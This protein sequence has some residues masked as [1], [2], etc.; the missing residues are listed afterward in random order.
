M[1]CS[2]S[3]EESNQSLTIMDNVSFDIFV[4]AL[5]ETEKFLSIPIA[6]SIFIIMGCWIVS[7]VFLFQLRWSCGFGHLTNTVHYSDWFGDITSGHDPRHGILLFFRI[8]PTSSWYLILF[9]YCWI[10]F[11]SILKTFI[12]VFVRNTDL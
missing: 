11:A 3:L 6:L 12:P 9:I 2:R 5:C 1:S 7:N 10:W 8:N 4:E